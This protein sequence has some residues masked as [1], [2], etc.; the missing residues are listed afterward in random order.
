METAQALVNVTAAEP[1]S[2]VSS[3]RITRAVGEIEHSRAGRSRAVAPVG[4]EPVVRVM[5]EGED[6]AVCDWPKTWLR[7]YAPRQQ[8]RSPTHSVVRRPALSLPAFL[9]SRG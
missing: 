6:A 1:A 8:A 5:V 4:T 7:P 9:T 3:V 2:I